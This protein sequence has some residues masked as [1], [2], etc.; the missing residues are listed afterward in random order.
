MRT[1]RPEEVARERVSG[2]RAFH[3]DD[4]FIDFYYD[5][6]FINPKRVF[7]LEGVTGRSRPCWPPSPSGCI[8]PTAHMPCLRISMPWAPIPRRGRTAMAAGC[9]AM[10]RNAFRPPVW[11]APHWSGG[12]VPVPVYFD[13][14]GYE[15]SFSHR[16]AEITG[17]W[18]RLCGE[19]EHPYAAPNRYNRIRTTFLKGGLLCGLSR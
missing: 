14:I 1:S 5:N 8:C 3:D 10:R 7:V 11:T 2:E 16:K 17:S 13:T 15:K 9:S 12:A 19:G 18:S 4:S 6:Y